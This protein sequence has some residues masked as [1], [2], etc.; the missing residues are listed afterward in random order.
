MEAC[1]QESQLESL[2]C[3]DFKQ[4]LCQ[5]I[6]QC[7]KAVSAQGQFINPLPSWRRK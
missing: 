7:D 3:V 5:H 2:G 6:V 1:I 4:P